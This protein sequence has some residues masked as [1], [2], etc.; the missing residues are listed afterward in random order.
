[1]GSQP[2]EGKWTWAPTLSQEAVCN[3]YL[4]EKEKS[5]FSKAVSLG[6][7]STLQDGGPCAGT[8]GLHKTLSGILWAVCLFMHCL[9]IC[10]LLIFCLL[11]FTCVFVGICVCVS[12]VLFFKE[13]KGVEMGGW[14]RSGRSW[15]RGKV[16]LDYKIHGIF[17]S[18]KTAEK[19][20]KKTTCFKY[21][22]AIRLIKAPTLWEG[23]HK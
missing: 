1:M 11:V 14:R 4:L 18:I 7:L 9:G 22:R 5:V 23:K 21:P 2:W 20:W 8:D 12:R 13:R 16:W 6:A 3:R 10:C 15:G 17:F 19:S